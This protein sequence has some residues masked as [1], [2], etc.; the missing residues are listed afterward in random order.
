MH[1]FI[2]SNNPPTIEA[3]SK[4]CGLTTRISPSSA[5]SG[6]GGE[7]EHYLIETI[8]LVPQSNLTKLQIG[9]A[10]VTEAKCGYVMLSKLE[11]YYLC[12]EF[13]NLPTSDYREYKCSLNPLDDNYEYKFVIHKK[14]KHQTIF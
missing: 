1:V 8:P 6:H 14:T 2:G 5:L 4:E 9:E 10:V 12:P 7:I 3:F 11:R 13:A